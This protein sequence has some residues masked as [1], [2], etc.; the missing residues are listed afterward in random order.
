MIQ[1]NIE[2]NQFIEEIID[3]ITHNDNDYYY[4]KTE[5]D[6]C[7]TNIGKKIH[8]IGGYK[9][10]IQVSNIVIDTLKEKEYNYTYLQQLSEMEYTWSE[11]SIEYKTLFYN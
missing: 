8:S 6:T 2:L 10:L 4:N 1:K 3:I 5:F 9:A 11:I 7:C